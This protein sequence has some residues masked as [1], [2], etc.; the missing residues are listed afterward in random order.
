MKLGKTLR[1]TG[2]RIAKDTGANTPKTIVDRLKG[3]VSA[4]FNAKNKRLSEM[5]IRDCTKALNPKTQIKS[6]EKHTIK[7]AKEH[8]N[9][10]K[11]SELLNHYNKQD[12]LRKNQSLEFRVEIENMSALFQDDDSTSLSNNNSRSNRRETTAISSS[13]RSDTD[14]LDSFGSDLE[15]DM[16]HNAQTHDKGPETD[17]KKTQYQPSHSIKSTD[18]SSASMDNDSIASDDSFHTTVMELIELQELEWN[19]QN[20]ETV[21]AC[22][23]LMARNNEMMTEQGYPSD[24]QFCIDGLKDFLKS[25]V[26]AKDPKILNEILN[27]FLV[28]QMQLSTTLREANNQPITHVDADDTSTASFDD[29]SVASNGDSIASDDT[30][31]TPLTPGE[32]SYQMA[33]SLLTKIQ[34]LKLDERNKDSVDT[35][36]TLIEQNS[37]LMSKQGY[38]SDSPFN[39]EGLKALLQSGMGAEDTKSLYIALND[40]MLEQVQLSMQLRAKS[41]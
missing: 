6:D 33:I 16:G 34:E 13:S 21:D 36:I 20:Q 3:A 8:G 14:R 26:N 9:V 41:S 24:S 40:L 17:R 30:F 23:S 31:F 27:E 25:D 29:D 32:Y 5:S 37:K 15:G 22:L 1:L 12:G 2:S 4:I 18:F 35:C 38:P 7:Y 19:A 28:E 39:L 11:Q 10:D